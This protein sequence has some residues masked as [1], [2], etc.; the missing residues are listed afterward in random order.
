M[1][2]IYPRITTQQ[3]IDT[4]RRQIKSLGFSYDWDREVDTTDP[5]YFKWTQW[6][7]L[8]IYDTWY[9][10]DAEEGPADRRAADPAP[11]CRRRATTPCGSTGTASGWPTR[12]RCR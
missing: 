3:N 8:T 12:P 2:S 5:D 9:D 11:R 7:F 6:I 4:F 1:P 10:P